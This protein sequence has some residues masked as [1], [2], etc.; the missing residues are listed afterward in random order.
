MMRPTHGTKNMGRTLLM[1]HKE[2]NTPIPQSV[3]TGTDT[4][5]LGIT[6]DTDAEMTPRVQL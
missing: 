2:F 3:I 4:L 6:V 1:E 5:F